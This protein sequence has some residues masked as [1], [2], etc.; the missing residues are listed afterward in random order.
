MTMTLSLRP[1]VRTPGLSRVRVAQAHL[2]SS[3]TREIAGETRDAAGEI[4]PAQDTAEQLP[5]P[6]SLTAALPPNTPQ[7]VALRPA[8]PQPVTA[9]LPPPPTAVP[10]SASISAPQA[11]V[12]RLVLP[13]GR[14]PP[15]NRG[16]HLRIHLSFR[17]PFDQP[18]AFAATLSSGTTG[19]R[20]PALPVSE[21]AAG[22][23]VTRPA[24]P[25]AQE[26][27]PVP[28]SKAV[29]LP[30]D[31]PTTTGPSPRDINATSREAQLLLLIERLQRE[32]DEL[33]QRQAGYDQL[34]RKNAE[35]SLL[36]AQSSA[37]GA[38]A[39][40]ASSSPATPG[41]G[42][43]SPNTTAPG[44]RSLAGPLPEDVR[45][46]PPRPA[47]SMSGAPSLLQVQVTMP[48]P[49]T[50]IG[51]PPPPPSWL[52]APSTPS[53][54]PPTQ[55]VVPQSPAAPSQIPSAAPQGLRLPQA[56]APP[57][58]PALPSTAPSATPSVS[59]SARD[60]PS[61]PTTSPPA[62]SLST[63]PALTAPPD[64]SALGSVLGAYRA[65]CAAG[66]RLA[67]TSAGEAGA[68]ASLPPRSTGGARPSDDVDQLVEKMRGLLFWPGQ[69]ER[70][71]PL[72][73]PPSATSP[74]ALIQLVCSL[75]SSQLADL[76]ASPGPLPQ[77]AQGKVGPVQLVHLL[78]DQLG[79]AA[80]APT[81]TGA[82]APCEPSSSQLPSSFSSTL[83]ATHTPEAT[84]DPLTSSGTAAP[85]T[86]TG[87]ATTAPP[88]GRHPHPPPLPSVPARHPDE[89]AALLS[90]LA[91]RSETIC[92]A[93]CPLDLPKPHT[94][95][96][97]PPLAARPTSP[98]LDASETTLSKSVFAVEKEPHM[99]LMA[100]TGCPRFFTPSL[101]GSPLS[102]RLSRPPPP[103]LNSLL[104]TPTTTTTMPSE[105]PVLR[106]I[107]HCQGLL[108]RLP[109]LP[110]PLPPAP[111]GA[112]ED[113]LR[114]Y[115]RL[116]HLMA[117]LVQT[118]CSLKTALR[119]ELMGGQALLA[120]LTQA[121]VVALPAPLTSTDMHP[122]S[123]PG[124]FSVPMPMA[125]LPTLGMAIGKLLLAVM[126]CTLPYTFLHE[127]PP[128][129]DGDGPA[130]VPAAATRKPLAPPPVEALLKHP[131]A[132]L[133][134]L[135]TI[136]SDHPTVTLQPAKS[137]PL[138][139]WCPCCPSWAAHR[140]KCIAAETVVRFLVGRPQPLPAGTE[141]D[142][143]ASGIAWLGDVGDAAVAV[144]ATSLAHH[145]R[146]SIRAARLSCGG[147]AEEQPR[148]EGAAMGALWRSIRDCLL[149]LGLLVG[150][151]R[152]ECDRGLDMPTRR[153]LAPLL[154]SLHPLNSDQIPGIDP[155]QHWV[156]A[157]IEGA[158]QGAPSST[159][160]E[161]CPALGLRNWR[162][163][164]A[165]G[166][167]PCAGP[168]SWYAKI[169]EDALA[170]LVV[171]LVPGVAGDVAQPSE[172]C[173]V[174]FDGVFV[175]RL[176]VLLGDALVVTGD[177]EVEADDLG[178]TAEAAQPPYPS[179]PNPSPSPPP[180][181]S[182]S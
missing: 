80:P 108:G 111:S 91:L 129:L 11:N 175:E 121:Y 145:L 130:P 170:G 146:G 59:P 44:P 3:Q 61:I 112:D 2:T 6:S 100:L 149:G 173:W 30:M 45:P 87:A 164:L 49:S 41:A 171:G 79:P 181:S 48:P 104:P 55:R 86:I 114:L 84:A 75:L 29:P 103:V 159:D 53:S 71:F 140:T 174:P 154:A 37:P 26:A 176:S 116:G 46:H 98:E 74:R 158:A 99:A 24:T 115:L 43:V 102:A 125:Q 95:V 94:A 122:L 150:A 113:A 68:T 155:H 13:D 156:A 65:A 70:V 28:P 90:S 21:H 127:A 110:L 180:S 27:S 25:P 78:V 64:E 82:P 17:I 143:P 5:P 153:S 73:Q 1:G 96:P 144:V 40:S 107:A 141:A 148:P 52:H 66:V 62:Y 10:P 101:K 152:N 19:A 81:A 161:A 18:L 147:T 57:P 33:K 51:P 169:G 93:V 35:L 47:R 72:P 172:R 14:S 83:S 76:L 137:D 88:T 56:A 177:P 120:L 58:P 89:A 63:S 4:S 16:A 135:A 133:Q 20:D 118:A 50:P 15:I 34:R 22:P 105:S 142:R 77:G 36:L 136:L 162:T 60:S 131:L 85:Q 42:R 23:Q 138:A 166:M 139:P 117:T 12:I 32:S 134:A 179:P 38:S 69:A 128:P 163:R 39:A 109:P 157:L 126:E 67:L 119:L 123:P 31:E 165:G 106:I 160:A 182:A 151:L 132:L 97:P 8:N 92:R 7:P 178:G 124:L 168:H 167:L 9:S 54:A